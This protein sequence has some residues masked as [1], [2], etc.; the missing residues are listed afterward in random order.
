M[1]DWFLEEHLM[2]VYLILR[3]PFIEQIMH[4]LRKFRRKLA[5][6]GTGILENAINEEV[7]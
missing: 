3:Y 6:F 4:D 5:F 7:Q 1:Q 2:P